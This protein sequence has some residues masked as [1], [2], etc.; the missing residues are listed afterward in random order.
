MSE[1]S[2]DQT[3]NTNN[4]DE[5]QGF[6]PSVPIFLI[7]T[8]LFCLFFVTIK[9]GVELV[10]HKHRYENSN[11]VQGRLIER[12][13]IQNQKYQPAYYLRY[14]IENPDGIQNCSLDLETKTT[15]RYQQ[16]SLIFARVR[17]GEDSYK[18]A[19]IPSNIE[20]LYHSNDEG[21]WSEPLGYSTRSRRIAQLIFLSIA[22]LFAGA[23]S[24]KYLK[25]SR[26]PK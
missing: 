18:A 14:K 24:W 8:A 22:S 1:E 9:T 15:P 6:S 23:F 25:A 17:V 10:K 16:C 2:F 26:S 21:T 13:K 5:E 12:V 19:I 20:V 4:V 11:S 7:G 3:E